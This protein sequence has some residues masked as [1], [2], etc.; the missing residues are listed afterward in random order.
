[1]LARALA[2]IALAIAGGCASAAPAAAPLTLPPV[3]GV[4]AFD[5]ILLDFNR[6]HARVVFRVEGLVDCSSNSTFCFYGTSDLRVALPRNCSDLASDSWS[7]GG[8]TTRVVGR[9]PDTGD[10]ILK[11]D[12]APLALFQYNRLQGVVGIYYDPSA[13]P[14]FEQELTP[15]VLRSAREIGAYH[16]RTSFDFLFRCS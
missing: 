16:P 5:T 13:Q 9:D 7:E 10:A 12:G 15:D 11:T 3:T 2:F 8:V 6:R 1:M 14:M 4:Y